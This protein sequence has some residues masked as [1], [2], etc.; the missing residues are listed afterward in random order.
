LNSLSAT[1]VTFSLPKSDFV[2]RLNILTNNPDVT[3]EEKNFVDY[4]ISPIIRSIIKMTSRM[5]AYESREA[6]L[7]S[8]NDIWKSKKIIK[9]KLEGYKADGIVRYN[10]MEIM[11]MEACD[12]F[13][14]MLASKI[15]FDLHKGLYECLAMLGILDINERLLL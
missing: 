11:I 7:N 1:N 12:G 5:L 6:F 4:F 2:D 10:N 14:N 13:G 9:S 8:I 3:E 15:Q